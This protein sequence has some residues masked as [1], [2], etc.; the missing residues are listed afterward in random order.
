[1][2]HEAEQFKT[3]SRWNFII[4]ESLLAQLTCSLF[5]HKEKKGKGHEQ[6]STSLRIS[7]QFS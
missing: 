1:V 5:V 2:S 4:K 6:V 7:D 3:I